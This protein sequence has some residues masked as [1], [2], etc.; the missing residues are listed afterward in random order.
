MLEGLN[1][2]GTLHIESTLF[3]GRTVMRDERTGVASMRTLMT[4]P[5]YP[6][7]RVGDESEGFI[8]DAQIM[9]ARQATW[10]TDVQIR[11]RDVPAIN[12][13]TGIIHAWGYT[14][15]DRATFDPAGR[16]DLIAGLFH[17]GDIVDD[18]VRP[19]INSFTI[20]AYYGNI[21]QNEDGVVGL[22]T[23]PS[24]TTL[25]GEID[26]DRDGKA[27]VPG[28][29][30]ARPPGVYPIEHYLRDDEKRSGGPTTQ[31]PIKPER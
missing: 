30:Y 31:V 23:R 14:R 25:D 27:E 5:F 1:S 13:V 17:L 7:G 11:I 21:T 4:I 20:G 15:P 22:N 29:H 12:N 19:Y 9:V 8:P 18:R 24:Y 6:S 28:E 10:E 3:T 16:M 26:R 2:D